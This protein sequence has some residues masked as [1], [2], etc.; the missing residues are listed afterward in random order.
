MRKIKALIQLKLQ[1]NGQFLLFQTKIR[2]TSIPCVATE[3]RQMQN[4]IFQ[5]ELSKFVTYK[6]E[7]RFLKHLS[8]PAHTNH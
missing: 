4:K 3:L 5:K 6:F 2:L 8:L 1:K 7:Q